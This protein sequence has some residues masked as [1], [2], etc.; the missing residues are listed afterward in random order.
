[1]TMALAEFRRGLERYV[2]NP[3]ARPFVCTG[4]PLNCRSFIVGRNAATRLSKPFKSYWSD[5]DGVDRKAFDTAM[6]RCGLERATVAL[7]RR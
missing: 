4:S 6:L 1:V 2:Q 5:Q 7:L 3:Y